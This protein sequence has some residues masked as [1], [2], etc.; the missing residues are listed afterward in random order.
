MEGNAQYGEDV[1]INDCPPGIRGHMTRSAFHESLEKEFG[2]AVIIKGRYYSP[3]EKDLVLPSLR[4][5]MHITGKDKEKV[6]AA[7]QRVRDVIQFGPN[8]RQYVEKLPINIP[9]T[10]IFNPVARILGPQAT[11]LHHI[12]GETKAQVNLRG[13][14]GTPDAH[15]PFMLEII[16]QSE[17]SVK[18]AKA[19]CENLLATVQTEFQA[20]QSAPVNVNHQMQMQM[21]MQMPY[22]QQGQQNMGQHNMAQ[23]N[24]AQNYANYYQGYYGYPPAD[25][26]PK[27]Q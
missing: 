20:F 2:I 14:P 1:D 17:E 27:Y 10:H 9:P 5:H 6:A 7:G 25:Q 11:Y 12:V 13:R 19:L 15:S 18:K 26:Q 4:L 21:Q 24:M 16:S 23:P 22:G 3:V 8:G